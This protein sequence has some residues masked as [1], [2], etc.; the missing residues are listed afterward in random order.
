MLGALTCAS[1]AEADFGHTGPKAR[2]M[3]G[4]NIEL[5]PVPFLWKV[6]YF[7]LKILILIPSHGP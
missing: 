3:V 4:P 6:A 2:R 1:G 5:M 7:V